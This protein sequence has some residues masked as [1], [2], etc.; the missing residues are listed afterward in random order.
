[1]SPHWLDP[2]TKAF[3]H[4]FPLDILNLIPHC[5]SLY[6]VCF[7]RMARLYPTELEKIL[8]GAEL[9]AEPDIKRTCILLE[10]EP[11]SAAMLATMKSGRRRNTRSGR[12]FGTW[13]GP[14]DDDGDGDVSGGSGGAPAAAASASTRGRSSKRARR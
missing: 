7:G 12:K 11:P 6:A 4:T 2:S 5:Y 14:D 9:L 3:F 8:P 13:G 10:I 1:M